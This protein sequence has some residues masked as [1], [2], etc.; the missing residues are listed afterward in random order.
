MVCRVLPWMGVFTRMCWARSRPRFGKIGIPLLRFV[1]W[2]TVVTMPR[3]IS[4]SGRVV[5]FMKRKSL[6][7]LLIVWRLCR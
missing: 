4:L 7:R 6:V 1:S 3:A 5:M 2:M